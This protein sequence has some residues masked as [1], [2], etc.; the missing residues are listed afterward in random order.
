[1]HRPVLVV[2]Y[3]DQKGGGLRLQH[4]LVILPAKVAI[5]LVLAELC[6]QCRLD[7]LNLLLLRFRHSRA[8]IGLSSEEYRFVILRRDRRD[9][10]PASVKVGV[11]RMTNA[12][13]TAVSFLGINVPRCV[14]K[15]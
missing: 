8:V 6:F 12:S 7:R 2:S 9:G 11:S 14:M 4:L 5:S 3:H 10:R 1:M 13:K 15:L